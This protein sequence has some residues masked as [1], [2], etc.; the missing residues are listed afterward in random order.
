MT[1]IFGGDEPLKKGQNVTVGDDLYG[2]SVAELSERIEI[3]KAEILRTEAAL[4][5]KR[6]ELSEA[7]T[8]FAPRKG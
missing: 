7:E 2:V 6:A 4:T 3:L 1:D 8:L 5:K